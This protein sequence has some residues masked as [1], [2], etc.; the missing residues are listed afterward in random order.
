[1]IYLGT[2]AI[3]F[4]YSSQRDA[5]KYVYTCRGGLTTVKKIND[6]ADF[7]AALQVWNIR[8]WYSTLKCQYTVAISPLVNIIFN[9]YQGMQAIGFSDHM[10]KT[11]WN[12]V[13]TV[14][15]MGNIEFVQNGDRCVPGNEHSFNRMAILL[16]TSP[17][18]V[19][20]AMTNRFVCIWTNQIAVLYQSCSQ[21]LI[22]KA[23][24]L[25]VEITNSKCSYW[26]IILQTKCL[27]WLTLC[28]DS[29]VAARGEVVV[30]PLTKAEAEYARDALAK[31]SWLPS[32][33]LWD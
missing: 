32:T 9:M 17:A 23:C 22:C 16:D 27:H 30:K 15:H 25:F 29:V 18:V 21:Q 19:I 6:K 13:A 8:C 28:L 26:H 4:M 12:L 7:N 3:T 5:S 11:I 31:V 33:R 2:Y 14:L 1:M 24:K 10:K 20:E